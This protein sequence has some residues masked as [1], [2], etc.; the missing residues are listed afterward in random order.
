VSLPCSAKVTITAVTS[1]GKTVT[2]TH[3]Y[4]LC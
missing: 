1:S 2:Q 3:T 4:N